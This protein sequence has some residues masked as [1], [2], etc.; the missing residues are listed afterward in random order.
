MSIYV[1]IS[2]RAYPFEE[3]A[4]SIAP[5]EWLA[6]VDREP[7][8]R[9]PVGSETEYVGPHARVFTGHIPPYVFDLTADGEIDVKSPPAPVIARMKALARLLG[10]NVFSVET[11]ETFDDQGNHAGFVDEEP[12]LEP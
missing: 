10:A 2:R 4:P 9:P 5:E 3:G 8:F 7:D 1:A 11:G 6:V 12:P